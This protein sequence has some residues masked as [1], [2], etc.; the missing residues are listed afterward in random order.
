MGPE[1]ILIGAGFVLMVVE[2]FLPASRKSLISWLALVAVAGSFAVSATRLGAVIHTYSTA[3]YVVDDFSTVFKFVILLG[4]A[5]VLAL[6]AGSQDRTPLPAEH[7][8]LLLFATAG[9]MV[10]ASALDLVVFYV[11]L[12]TLSI[13]TYILVAIRRRNARSAEGG[14]KYLIVGS[15]GSA[16]ILYGLSFLFGLAGSTSF[17]QISLTLQNASSSNPAILYLSL[18]LVLAGVGIKISAVPFHL[19]TADVYE[20]APTAVTAYLAVVSKAAVFAFLL[21]FFVWVFAPV[22][23]DFAQA[24]AW[25]SVATMIV[26]NFGALAQRNLKRLLAYSSISQA[27]YLLV[28]FAALGP[29]TATG[30]MWQGLSATLFYL[31]AYV[32]MTVGA[33]AVFALVSGSRATEDM[34]GF[35]G[36]YRRSPWLAAAM[37]VFM[38]SLAG[39]PLTAGFMGKF[40]IFLVAFNTSQFWLGVILFL[41]SAVAFYYY[42]GVLR[43][44]FAREPAGDA[45]RIAGS[46]TVHTVIGVCLAG[47]L[48]LGI[49]P[50]PLMHLLAGLNWFG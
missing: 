5:L 28:P 34:D 33:F 14:L 31:F 18:G 32:F 39:M 25:I 43:A 21:R 29:A 22:L 2:L 13:A 10:I 8:Y 24:A 19:W 17:A 41:T 38:L 4:A 27:G 1:A 30:T 42:F 47:T 37:A 36:L 20:G 9:A 50:Q 11:G 15:I 16:T 26:G 49:F 44:M 40:M 12:E 35:S 6:A 3:V 7:A 23:P 45:E 46:A 48:F